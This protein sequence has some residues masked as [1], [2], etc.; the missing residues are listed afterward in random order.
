MIVTDY[1]VYLHVSRSGGTFLNDLIMDNVPGA[2]MIQYHGHLRDLPEQYADLPVIGFVRNP[3][4]WYISMYYDYRRK[5]QYVFQVLSRLG[6]LNFGETVAGF[7][8]LGNGSKESKIA[9]RRLARSAPRAIDPDRPRDRDVP[10]LKSEHFANYPEGLGYYSWLFGLM[11]ESDRDHDIRIGRF[12]NLREET[13]RLFEET[14]TPVTES[15]KKYV[16]DG[17]PQ[18]ASSRP[19]SIIGAYAPELECLVYEREKHLI[20][21]FGYRLEET[22]DYPKTDH[23]NRLGTANVDA[24]IKHVKD[25]PESVWDAEN[26]SKPNT[27]ERLNETRHIMFRFISDPENVFESSDHPTLWDDWKDLLLPV[28][29]QAAEALGYRDYSFP[30]VMF[31]RLPAGGE[32]SVHTDSEASFYIHKIHVPLITNDKTMFRVGQK[33]EHL[34]V[35]EIVEVNNKRSHGVRNDGGEDRIHLIFE[36]FNADDYGKS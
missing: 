1:F 14:G 6:T 8:N 2:R 13:I 11:F 28:M 10:G 17:P 7:L 24:L 19:S 34:P 4:D 21:R 23:F 30:R 31:A 3:F 18:N 32:I 25:I 5:E 29:T 22:R 27:F 15:I 35:G 20:E 9:L 16:E 12:E 33:E 26:D 36:C